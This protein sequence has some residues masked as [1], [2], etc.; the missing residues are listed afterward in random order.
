MIS[1]PRGGSGHEMFVAQG[2]PESCGRNIT[3]HSSNELLTA[4]ATYHNVVTT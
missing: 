1:K 3:E 2:Q 4:H